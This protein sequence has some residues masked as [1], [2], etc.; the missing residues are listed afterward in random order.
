MASSNAVR[1]LASGGDD[2][3]LALKMYWEGQV[4]EAFRAKTVLWDNTGNVIKYKNITSGKSWQ[5]IMGGTDPT[6]EYHTPGTE[7]LG[8]T[9]SFSE[10]TVTVDD[11]LVA[12]F[13]V[14][15]DQERM[16]HFDVLGNLGR[17]LGR[18][19]AIDFDKKLLRVAVNA[20]RATESDGYVAAGNVLNKTGSNS[21]LAATWSADNTGATALYKDVSELAEMLDEDNVP[22]ENRFLFIHPYLRYVLTQF[23]SP[24]IFNR[25]VTSLPGDLNKRVIGTLAGFNVVITNQLP[26]SNVSTGP[27]AYQGNFTATQASSEDFGLPAAVALCGT[28]DDVA[29]IGLVQAGPI[30]PYQARDE[31]RNTIFMKAQMVVGAGIL[32][33]WSAGVIQ[34]QKTS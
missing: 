7:L 4:L 21:T 34:V 22:E 13:D 18:A 1:F 28:V 8:Q 9:Y 16:S 11:I 14:P 20:A 24:N 31:R 30:Y 3:A 2:R 5:F 10:G 29:A 17:R 32:C 27:T 26:S 6:P 23:T 15:I 25:D 19:L 33:P 12:H